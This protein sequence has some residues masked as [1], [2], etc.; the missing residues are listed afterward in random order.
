MGLVTG[1]HAHIPPHPHPVGSGPRHPA[2][3]ADSRGGRAPD[4]GRPTPWQEAPPPGTLRPP[5]QHAKAR[6]V[7]LVT[8]PH[9]RTPPVPTASG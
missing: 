8:G 1:P 2:Q 6:A 9:A 7:G 5:P 4:P 3:R